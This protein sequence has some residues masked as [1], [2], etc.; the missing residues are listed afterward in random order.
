MLLAHDD[1]SWHRQVQA[2]S[3]GAMSTP[4]WLP[5]GGYPTPTT[6]SSM[7]RAQEGKPNI[8]VLRKDEHIGTRKAW[9][10]SIWRGYGCEETR[11]QKAINSKT[12]NWT[13]A[14]HRV[15]SITVSNVVI[16]QT[17]QSGLN[18][19]SY[20]YSYQP[21]LSIPITKFTQCQGCT[22]LP[23]SWQPRFCFLGN[24][25]ARDNK[26]GGLGWPFLNP[27]NWHPSFGPI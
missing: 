24:Y 14:K 25:S 16:E 21:F 23:A 17:S 27:V 15:P 6:M 2:R 19:G 13:T 9:C 11:A 12:S 4:S 8:P 3:R 7:V 22:R 10:L 1:D 18:L 5:R 26:L 20:E